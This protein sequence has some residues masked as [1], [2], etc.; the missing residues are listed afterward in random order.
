MDILSTECPRA[1]ENVNY[2]G[3]KKSMGILIQITL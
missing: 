3:K 1:E 2:V